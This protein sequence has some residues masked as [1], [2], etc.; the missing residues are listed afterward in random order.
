MFFCEWKTN[1]PYHL[2]RD[3]RVRS[4]LLCMRDKAVRW[5]SVSPSDGRRSCARVRFCRWL[6]DR[7]M[8][9]SRRD[10]RWWTQGGESC[11]QYAVATRHTLCCASPCHAR[12]ARRRCR[13]VATA[14]L[15]VRPPLSSAAVRSSSW[16][17]WVRVW[18]LSQ[19]AYS[20]LCARHSRWCLRQS[21]CR[22]SCPLISISSSFFLPQSYFIHWDF[23]PQ[24]FFC[25]PQIITD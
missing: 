15:S 3:D 8:A 23:C 11:W 24:S 5:I 16:C 2:I 25:C 19:T 21:A 1:E 20:G 9:K 14:S 6:A 17:S 13:R 4:L 18:W 12:R 7:Q 22:W 10:R